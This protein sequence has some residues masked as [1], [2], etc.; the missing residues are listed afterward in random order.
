MNHRIQKF[1]GSGTFLTKWGSSGTG[2][3]Q[4]DHPVGVAVDGL[5]NVYVTDGFNHR[6]Q[7]FDGSGTFLTKWGTLGTGDG[8][9]DYP[10]DIAVDGSGHVYVTDLNIQRIQKFL[11]E[12]AVPSDVP[13]LT[14]WGLIVL[15][16]LVALGSLATLIS[17]RRRPTAS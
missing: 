3:G 4:F 13:A 7:K 11:D 6:N 16:V 14:P 12:A 8:Q 17:R 2:D 1:D 5:G 10:G 15:V 9:F